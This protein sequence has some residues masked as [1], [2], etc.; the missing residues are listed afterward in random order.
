MTTINNNTKAAADII[1]TW[2]RHKNDHKGI[3]AAY[4]RPSYRKVNA[5]NSIE[6][7]AKETAGY[8]NDLTV[9]G[10]GSS[11][12]S[13]I[14][15]YTDADGIHIVKDTPSNTFLVTVNK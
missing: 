4:G 15:S 3:F 14:Y 9:C 1:S 5:Y 10:A 8:N 2:N 13:T 7:R 12:F 11:F 6:E